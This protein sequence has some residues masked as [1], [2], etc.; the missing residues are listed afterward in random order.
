MS[1]IKRIWDRIKKSKSIL[2]PTFQIDSS[3]YLDEN[4]SVDK[5][6][7]PR[8]NYFE[9][10]LT[11]QFLRDRREYWNEYIPLTLFLTEFIYSN[12]RSSFP[13]VV[14]PDLLKSLEQIEGDESIRYKNTRVVGPTPYNGDN[15]TLFTGLFRVK[16]KNWAAQTIG[17]LETVA[18]SFDSSKL[19]G[20]LNIAEPLLSG[21]EGFFGMG[22]D[23]Q[24]R[25][26]QRDE[27]RDSEIHSTNVFRGGYWVMIRDDQDKVKKE[28]FW[29]KNSQL[30]YGARKNNIKPYK[31]NDYVLFEISASEKRND[32]ETFE[33]H[34]HWEEAREAIIRKNL[35]QA[36][37]ELQS[38]QVRLWNS[39]DII[40]SQKN[41]LMAMYISMF[42]DMKSKFLGK[43]TLND[44]VESLRT[45]RSNLKNNGLDIKFPINAV[46]ITTELIKAK[47]VDFEKSNFVIDQKFIEET[48][49]NPILNGPEILNL[50]EYRT[51]SIS[52]SI[53][54]INEK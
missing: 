54:L 32:Y 15:I 25:I 18:K 1:F 39:D 10:S 4:Q 37:T 17:L 19:T 48:L 38:L 7:S 52:P 41:Q 28:N 14:G 47:S 50:T 40:E 27:F 43:S 45:N 23:M 20:Y 11:E 24:F 3:K 9:I 2:Y 12:K 35:Q 6:I 34:K 16:T 49:D 29:V 36:E 30:Y 33:F 13:F 53:E 5:V 46:S 51:G 26:G 22:D 31:E 21:I 42:E 44:L 8:K